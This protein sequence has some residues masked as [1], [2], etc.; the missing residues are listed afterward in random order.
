M[1]PLSQIGIIT[2]PPV[3]L[4]EPFKFNRS[5]PAEYSLV[6]LKT[7]KDLGGPEKF[8]DWKITGERE[9][10]VPQRMKFQSDQQEK[11]NERLV[12]AGF[13]EDVGRIEQIPVLLEHL[14]KEG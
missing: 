9:I 8:K 6:E 7:M 1:T 10:F 12:A 4:N 2:N 14:M 11:E 13:P 5:N 3:S